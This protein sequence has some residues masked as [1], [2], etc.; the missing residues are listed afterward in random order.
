VINYKALVLFYAVLYQQRYKMYLYN[1]VL[2]RVFMI[3]SLELASNEVI[4]SE[5]IIFC[6]TRR[7]LDLD[8]YII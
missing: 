1:E 7:A 6:E 5:V 3:Q 2:K 4:V 8:E